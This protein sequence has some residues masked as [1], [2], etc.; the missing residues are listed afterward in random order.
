M[1]AAGGDTRRVTT[2]DKVSRKGSVSLSLWRGVEEGRL[3]AKKGHVLLLTTRHP[4][5]Q[6]RVLFSCHL[7]E[8]LEMCYDAAV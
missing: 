1:G 7:E 2:G 4:K 5:S 3:A 6:L 8:E